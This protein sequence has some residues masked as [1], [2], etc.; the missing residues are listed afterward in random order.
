MSYFEITR[1][2][3]KKNI[4][5]VYA[6]AAIRGLALAKSTDT[7]S[8]LAD[9]IKP[10][11]G[12]LTRDVVVGGPVLADHVYPGR[13]ELPFTAGTEVSTA[14]ADALEIEGTT[15]IQAASSILTFTI[16]DAGS[17]YTTAPTVTFT[18]GAGT[19]AAATATTDG[20]TITAVT[21]TNPG[22]GFTS[23]PTIGFTGGGGSA[24]AA[25]VT[26]GG[27]ISGSTAVGTEISFA[28]GKLVTKLAYQTA[29]YV[30]VAQ[31]TPEVAGNVR[32]ALQTIK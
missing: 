2:S 15:M 26:I 21:V 9:G 19:G 25:T 24:A 16:T 14:F 12:H 18:G 30:I 8:M 31:L 3:P 5:T 28:A 32:L 13:L 17:G 29:Y 10:F 11:I 6:I 22:S 20:S 7:V 1:S 4:S 23:A 27:L